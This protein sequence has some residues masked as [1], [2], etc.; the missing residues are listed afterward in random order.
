MA[1]GPKT[2]VVR[3][4][5]SENTWYCL[6]RC[7][8]EVERKVKTRQIYCSLADNFSKEDLPPNWVYCSK[9]FDEEN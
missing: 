7:G 1:K 4:E 6:L 5:R 3:V 9:C 8:H 2:D